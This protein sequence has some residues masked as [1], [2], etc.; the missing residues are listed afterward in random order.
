MY[1][2]TKGLGQE[3]C[4]VFAANN[5]SLQVIHLM[6]YHFKRSLAPPEGEWTPASGS[7]VNAL[8]VTFADGAKAVAA[9]LKV[10]TTSLESN[11]EAFFVGDDMPNGRFLT[12][13]TKKYLNWA[14]TESIAKFFT[15]HP[16]L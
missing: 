6:Y 15:H 11:C 7:L 1:A 4:R 10:D 8:G 3:I 16:K 2:I 12:D 13:R 5:P 14:P 9:A